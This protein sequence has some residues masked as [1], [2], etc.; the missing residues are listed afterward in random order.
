MQRRFSADG[1]LLEL[2]ESRAVPPVDILR[3]GLAILSVLAGLC[4]SGLAG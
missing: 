1:A 4:K 3:V 2:A